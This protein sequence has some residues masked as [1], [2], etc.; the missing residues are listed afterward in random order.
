MSG[1]EALKK[2]ILENQGSNKPYWSPEKRIFEKSG[3]Q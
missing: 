1:I 2:V 3:H